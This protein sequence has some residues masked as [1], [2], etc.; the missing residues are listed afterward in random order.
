M[1]I[2]YVE[3]C[4]GAGGTRSG[5]DAAGWDCRLA[6]DN[7]PDAATVHTMA[8]GD[9]LLQDIR[10]ISPEDIPSADVW[11]AGFPCQPFSTSGNKLGFGHRQGNVFESLARLID[12]KTPNM[13]LLE[14]VEGLLKNKAGHTF[15]KVLITLSQ[16]GYDVDWLLLNLRWFGVP[17]TRPRLFIAAQKRKKSKKIRLARSV[18]ASDDQSP[19][20][21]NLFLPL[22]DAMEIGFKERARGS[23][24]VVESERQPA[25]GVPR[26]QTPTPFGALGSASADDFQ[27]FDLAFGRV[28]DLREDLGSVVAP[29]FPHKNLI[30]SCRYYARG[31]PTKLSTRE[32]PVSHCIGTSLGGAPLYAVPSQ[33][34]AHKREEEAFLEFSN[35]HRVQDNLLVMRLI[36]EQA[37]KLFGPHTA[38]VQR[39]LFDCSISATRKYKLVGNMVAPVCAFE[40]AKLIENSVV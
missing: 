7:D 40:I 24:K 21:N 25:I 36:P 13:V 22:L 37:I 34:L 16:L 18:R 12:L 17:Q 15:S 11:V 23:L 27:S 6:V 33:L 9:V 4:A 29:N 5:L 10:V 19:K 26:I 35:W 8:H 2:N 31:G 39:A 28:F 1:V 32:D 3:F 20:K 38:N 30:K 14:N